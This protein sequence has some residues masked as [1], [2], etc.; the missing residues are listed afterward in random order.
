LT[1]KLKK[2]GGN[3]PKKAR[4]SAYSVFEKS[5]DKRHTPATKAAVKAA[6]VVFE[7]LTKMNDA[8]PVQ[9]AGRFLEFVEI[10]GDTA[11]RFVEAAEEA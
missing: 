4:K 8:T 3:T 6:Y 7:S 5:I 2:V 9:A 1:Y 10:M 11:D